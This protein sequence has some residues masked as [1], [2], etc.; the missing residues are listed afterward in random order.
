MPK[1]QAKNTRM[2]THFLLYRPVRDP[3]V[4]LDSK[5][6]PFIL[7]SYP[8]VHSAFAVVSSFILI[9]FNL[10]SFFFLHTA[11]LSVCK[12]FCV[13]EVRDLSPLGLIC[14]CLCVCGTWRI[15]LSLV[16]DIE[17]ARNKT[18]DLSHCLYLLF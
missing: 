11:A 16:Q 1:P 7:H 8:P 5:C 13:C 6:H 4:S 2:R 14:V 15:I 3:W 12:Q 18:F 17:Q 10:M 9:V